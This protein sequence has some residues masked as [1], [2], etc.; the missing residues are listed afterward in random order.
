MEQRTILFIGKPGCGKGTQAKLISEKLGVPIL[1]SGE[2]FR[3]IA[4]EDSAVGRKVKETIDQGLLMPDWF[5]MYL[6]Q[7]SIFSIP[8]NS[9]VIFDGFGRKLPEAELVVN[10][11]AWLGRKL[12]VVHINVSDEHILNRI[13]KRKGIEGRVDDANAVKRLEE[14]RLYTASCVEFFRAQGVVTEINGEPDVETIH[15]DIV[16]RLNLV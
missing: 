9:G 12:E 2:G 10:V 8:E 3:S 16:A 14:F 7:K 4:K 11:L 6:F 1:A 15:K 13:E 5:A